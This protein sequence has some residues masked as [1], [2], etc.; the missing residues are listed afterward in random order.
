MTKPR[1]D[2]TN[3]PSRHVTVGPSRAPHRSYYYAM[4]M[5]EDEIYQPLVGAGTK[6]RPVTFRLTVRHRL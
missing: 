6:L 5:T 2:K 1:M 4:G 3:L